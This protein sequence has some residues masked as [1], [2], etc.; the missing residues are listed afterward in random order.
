MGKRNTVPINAIHRIEMHA[1]GKL[2]FPKLNGPGSKSLSPMNLAA[3]GMAYAVP[4]PISL[5]VTFSRTGV[6]HQ[7][8][9]LSLR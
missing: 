7:H 2:H 9:D 8:K 4:A 6:T 3:M 1:T 5:E